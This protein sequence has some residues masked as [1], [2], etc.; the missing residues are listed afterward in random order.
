MSMTSTRCALPN[1]QP[2]RNT[3]GDVVL[4]RDKIVASK[5]PSASSGFRSVSQFDVFLCHNSLDKPAVKRIAESLKE[6]G[7]RPWL[8]EWS[9]GPVFRGKEHSNRKSSRS[10]R[11]QFLLAKKGSAL[12]NR[13]NSMRFCVSSLN[14]VFL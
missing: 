14:V 11:P 6:L 5:I 2:A 8:D 4:K 12:G 13:W 10:V 9:Y 1:S 7:I 3:I